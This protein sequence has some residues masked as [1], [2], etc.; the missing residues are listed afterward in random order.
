MMRLILCCSSLLSAAVAAP[1]P[2]DIQATPEAGGSQ[3]FLTRAVP[4]EDPRACP[5]PTTFNWAST[6]APIAEPQHGARRFTTP[7]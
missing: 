1:V 7:S 3:G 2:L 6:G 5:L 4:Q